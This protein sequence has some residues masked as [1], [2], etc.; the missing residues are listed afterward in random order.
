MEL[1]IGAGNQYKPSQARAKHINNCSQVRVQPASAG[2]LSVKGLPNFQVPQKEEAKKR[3][4]DMMQPSV[5]DDSL[6]SQ[7]D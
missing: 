4:V 3:S 7:V 5:W 6:H 1:I 2:T